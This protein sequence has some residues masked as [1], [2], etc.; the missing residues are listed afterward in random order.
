MAVMFVF[1]KSYTYLSLLPYIECHV[2]TVN[3]SYELQ[4][5]LVPTH[6]PPILDVPFPEIKMRNGLNNYPEFG[7][8]SYTIN[9]PVR[10][11]QQVSMTYNMYMTF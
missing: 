1:F 2:F 3:Y 6:A 11:Y 10:E 8:R 4:P 5:A 9:L 7:N